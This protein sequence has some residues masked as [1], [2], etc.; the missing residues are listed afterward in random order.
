MKYNLFN[1][2]ISRAYLSAKLFFVFYES[3]K[4][5]FMKDIIHWAERQTYRK[6]SQLSSYE[7]T[8]CESMEFVADNLAVQ[9]A[10][11]FIVIRLAISIRMCFNTY[12]LHIHPIRMTTSSI[13]YV[14]HD[15]VDISS[16]FTELLGKCSAFISQRT[17]F[18]TRHFTPLYRTMSLFLPLREVADT[19]S[20]SLAIY[21]RFLLSK[22]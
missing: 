18:T 6:K 10:F 17:I 5:K 12:A 8:K 19:L 3:A 13:F 15:M 20:S 1:R 14:G 9:F 21:F 22:L 7:L 16:H 2:R 11:C 4:R